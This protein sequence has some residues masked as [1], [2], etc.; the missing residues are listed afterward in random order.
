MCMVFVQVWNNLIVFRIVEY[1]STKVVQIPT[2][3]RKTESEETSD[4]ITRFVYGTFLFFFFSRL[5]TLFRES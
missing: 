3:S 1:T 5:L 4:R 2:N